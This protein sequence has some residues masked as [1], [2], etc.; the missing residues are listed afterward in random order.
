MGKYI[1]HRLIAR[2]GLD[3]TFW[4]DTSVHLS[5]EHRTKCQNV[6]APEPEIRNHFK[7]NTI[8]G[9]LFYYL[10]ESHAAVNFQH[11]TFLTFF[12]GSQVCRK[13]WTEFSRQSSLILTFPSSSFFGFFPLRYVVCYRGIQH[14]LE[15]FWHQIACLK[16][17]QIDLK[18]LDSVKKHMVPYLW[19][20]WWT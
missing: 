10:W 6:K 4:D 16:T 12:D 14:L 5:N 2:P 15:A 11:Y 7:S 17:I 3:N 8:T 18:H 9:T 20:A 19:P 1:D 13:C